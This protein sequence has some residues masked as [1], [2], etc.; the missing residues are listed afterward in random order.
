M[1]KKTIDFT[2]RKE[3][4][5][6]E[7]QK[8]IRNT[9]RVTKI[10]ISLLSVINV[11]GHN[12]LKGGK[13]KVFFSIVRWR[14]EKKRSGRKKNKKKL[15]GGI[16]N[17]MEELLK[18]LMGGGM[19][20]K[21]EISLLNKRESNVRFFRKLSL[22]NVKLS[23]YAFGILQVKLSRVPSNWNHY[24]TFRCILLGF[25]YFIKENYCLSAI[26]Q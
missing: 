4:I 9:K 1:K 16:K 7:K 11:V 10:I 2:S 6:K 20:V 14:V 19:R 12:F 22:E 17:I 24:G 25:S 26:P 5:L 13:K 15:E 21:L 18:S 8:E 23:A 3:K